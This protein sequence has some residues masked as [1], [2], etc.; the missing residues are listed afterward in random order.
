M[1]YIYAYQA[2][3][4]PFCLLVIIGVSKHGR[5]ELWL[6]SKMLIE[7]QKR[8]LRAKFLNGLRARALTVFLRIAT[9][10]AALAF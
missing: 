5:K 6:C 10:D 9:G 4:N 3:D 2:Q 7:R 8:T 1:A